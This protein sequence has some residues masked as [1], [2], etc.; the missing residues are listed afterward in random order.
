MSNQNIILSICIPTYNRGEFL[1]S[2][3]L[4]IFK[5]IENNPLVEVVVSDNH[6]TDDTLEIV[7]PFHQFNN[8]KY[9]RQDEN[10]GMS[11]NILDVVSKAKGEFCW[12]IGD[13]DFILQGAIDQLIKLI[14]SNKDVDFYYV[15]LSGIHINEYRKNKGVFD[16][17]Y[18]NAVP[19]PV[20][21]ELIDKW[22]KLIGPK[23]SSIFMGELMAS[24]FRR[25]IWMSHKVHPDNGFLSNIENSYVFTVIYANTFFGKKSMY[26][27]TP[28]ILVLDGVRD[29]WD[30]LGYILIVL[31]KELLELHREKGLKN[32]TLRECYI[33][34]IEMTLPF[35]F[36]YTLFKSRFKDK[37]PVKKYWLFL[38]THPLHTI[39]ALLIMLKKLLIKGVNKG[40][41]YLAP[42][43]HN[44][45]KQVVTFKYK[46]RLFG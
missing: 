17:T 35:A 4:S 22:E 36:R 39:I 43:F 11:K 24:V 26:I 18:C 27:Y 29:W 33:A 6:S 46:K 44:Y 45:L 9:F 40:L 21:Y 16:S 19:E 13:D 5:Q 37:I 3:L 12:L 25:E 15:K 41:K 38:C 14:E 32:P 2:S 1:N 10:V 28:M 42:S 7:K 23:Y 30:R 31:G 8:F 34:Y 20:E